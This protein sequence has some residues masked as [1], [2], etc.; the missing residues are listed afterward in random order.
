MTTSNTTT[1]GM[2]R[3]N[4]IPSNISAAGLLSPT[5]I[6]AQCFVYQ[7]FSSK[8]Q[9]FMIGYVNSIYS[10]YSVFK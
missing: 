2:S 3:S 7:Q 1:P 9:A 6:A 5:S 10:D 8:L 4:S